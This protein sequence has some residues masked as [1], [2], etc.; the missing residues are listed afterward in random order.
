[1]IVL[2]I[3]RYSCGPGSLISVPSGWVTSQSGKMRYVLAVQVQVLERVGLPI[4]G[5]LIDRHHEGVGK[6]DEVDA[7]RLEHPPH[8]LEDRLDRGYEIDGIHL[9]DEIERACLEPRQVAHIALVGIDW[10]T[11]VFGS[12]A[13]ALEL[14]VREVEHADIRPK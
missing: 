3:W 5:T 4:P 12:L 9:P 8:P 10:I 1:M 2:R 6:L 14:H 7:A 11:V 13:V